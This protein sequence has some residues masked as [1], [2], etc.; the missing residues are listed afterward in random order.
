MAKRDYY[1]TLG[2]KRGASADEIKSAYRKQARKYHPD[3]NKAPDAAGKFREATEA[4]EVLSDGEKR[5]KYD[6]FGHAGP[7]GASAGGPGRRGRAG[8]GGGVSFDFG[9]LFGG[10]GGSSGFM[11]MSLDDILDALRGGRGARG[12]RSGR[13]RARRPRR[14]GDTESHLTLE[15]LQAV[16]GTTTRLRM[17]RSDEAGGTHEETIEVKIPAGVQEGSKVRV[18][19]KGQLGGAGPGDLYIHVHVRPHPYFR[20]EGDDVY[21]H[22]PIS[23]AEAALGAKVDVPT[24]DGT[25]RV[26]IPPGTSSS[27]RLRLRGKGVGRAG[28][29]PGDEYVVIEIVPP[30][31]LDERQQRLIEEFARLDHDDPRARCPWSKDPKEASER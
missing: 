9:D 11:G 19:G 16:H 26:T 1:E 8:A 29:A 23:I 30:T 25:S 5:A 27:K 10:G 28:K 14:G 3:A 12:G 2:V 17:T 24:L 4:Y 22:V 31:R 7:A 18:R 13:Q 15:F 20:R 6:R 21:V